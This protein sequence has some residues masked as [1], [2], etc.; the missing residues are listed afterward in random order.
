MHHFHHSKGQL[1]GT[2]HSTAELSVPLSAVLNTLISYFAI[3]I[4]HLGEVLLIS[5][6]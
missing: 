6:S 1:V 5:K 4:G 2:Q 3:I